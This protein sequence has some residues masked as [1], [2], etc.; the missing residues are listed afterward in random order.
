MASAL[1]RLQAQLQT[2]PKRPGVYIMRN[3]QAEVIYV[4]K[5]AS[6]RSRVRSYF[7]SPH[8]LEPK[9]RHLVEQIADFEYIVT[10][11]AQEALILEA[12]LVKRHQ[13]FFNVRLKDDKHYP[14]LKVSLNEPWPRVEITRRVQPDGARYFG[15]YASAGSVRKTLDLVKK[16]FPW[17]SCTKVITGTDPRPCLDYFIHRCIAPCSG[18]CS[19]EE[20]DNVIRQVI[21]FLEGR[22]DEVVRE[23]R[24]KMDEAAEG[25][26]FERAAVLRDQIGAVERVTERQVMAAVAAVDTDVFGL[27][28]KDN[29]A[30]VQV[31][32]IRGGK[33]I[34]RDAFTLE[35]VADEPE[36]QVM[37]SFLKQFYQS[38][39]YVPRRLLLP[40][41]PAE[42][43]LI[44]AWLSEMR[45]GKAELVVP[46]RGAKRQLVAT[47]GENAREALQV[48][49]AK[50]LAD[51]GK[52]RAALEELQ[53]ELNL[54]AVP[55]RIEC[56]D[57]SN[58]Q[59][60]AAV[61][62]MVVFL[63]GRP[64]PAQYRRFRI[65]SVAGANDYAMLQ[66]V[67]RRRFK[68]AAKA[69]AHPELVEGPEP[70]P[71][72]GPP[73]ADVEPR[74]EEAADHDE[75]FGNP[76]DL[77]IVDGG[78]GQLSAALDVMRDLAVAQIPAAGLAKQHE[79]LFVK[80][81]SEPIVLPRTSQ[82]LYLVQRIRDEAH[83]FAITYHRNVRQ[84]AG[85]RSALDGVPGIG[86]KRKQ[87]LLRKFGSVARIR[88]ASPDDIAAT[89]GFTRAL[90]DKV[91]EYL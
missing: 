58:I 41:C 59:G 83:R 46:Q 13:P 24:L 42:A 68:R 74:A 86:P 27:A 35:G 21:L 55:Q 80:D 26:E 17:R 15:P 51:T 4:G 66:E 54:P 28:R 43:P 52:T 40:T 3:A 57:I 1:E 36:D 71:E 77:V 30:C 7:G 20:Y 22:V 45:G 72:A 11:S 18:Y 47:A 91:R 19:K 8:S 2:L 90:A 16:L 29:Q 87:A 31:F 81:V 50:W 64:A 56:Y 61:G 60:T 69:P 44:Q 73:P 32:F 37:A 12:T 85:I 14:Y 78:K 67:L 53:E 39:T 76:P 65:K 89:P 38:A 9:T 33:V 79:E 48:M 34:G 88:E 49:Q 25:L 82:A 10:S 6:L 5:A 75:S 70:P 84:K 63:D 23:L 62:S